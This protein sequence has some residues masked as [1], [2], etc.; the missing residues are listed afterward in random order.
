VS[1]RD[2][3]LSFL[4]EASLFSAN[5]KVKLQS[6]QAVFLIAYLIEHPVSHSRLDLS[7][8]E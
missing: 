8:H 7:I 1:T 4:G 6:K 5:K 3:Q 2:I